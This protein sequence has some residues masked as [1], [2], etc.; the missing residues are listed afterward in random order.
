MT[1]GGPNPSGERADL[2]ASLDKAR[3][4]LRYTLRDL[5]D[6]QAAERST[7]SGLCLGG[8]VKH[9][10]SVEQQWMRFIEIGPAAMSW[11]ASSAHDWTAGFRMEEGDTV[12]SLLEHYDDVAR[13]TDALVI[14]L[15][16]LDASHPLPDTPWFERGARWT[17]RRVLLHV[18][19]ETAQHAGHADI[20]RESIDG[21]RSMG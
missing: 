13:D 15:P 4:F 11:D 20:I 9:V 10:A 19:A 18:I 14:A 21:A 5:S 16:D 2:L 8:V 3:H 7:V 1:D 6:A 12:A 17:A